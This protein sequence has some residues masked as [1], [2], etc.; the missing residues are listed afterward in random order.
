[1]GW[2]KIWRRILILFHL[3]F[4]D[5][6]YETFMHNMYIVLKFKKNISWKY[7][8]IKNSDYLSEIISTH[9]ME[10]AAVSKMPRGMLH[11]GGKKGREQSG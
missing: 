4:R 1:M 9:C 8:S 11:H 5:Y 7:W 3:Y 6:F 2:N 10:V